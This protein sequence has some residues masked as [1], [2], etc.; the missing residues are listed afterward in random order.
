MK[1]IF[2]CMHFI[3]CFLL[4]SVAHSS[5]NQ[6]L[7]AIGVPV[8]T[9]TNLRDQPKLMPL[10]EWYKLC[11]NSLLDDIVA[12]IGVNRYATPCSGSK[13]KL[14][15]KV[16]RKMKEYQAFIDN[17]RTFQG[18]FQQEVAKYGIYISIDKWSR[19][20]DGIQQDLLL[21]QQYRQGQL[22]RSDVKN[23]W[24]KIRDAGVDFQDNT[25]VYQ[26]LLGDEFK[27][28]GWAEDGYGHTALFCIG[29]LNDQQQSVNIS[30]VHVAQSQGIA[31]KVYWTLNSSEPEENMA[32]IIDE[33]L[34]SI[35]TDD[36]NELRRAF[37][38]GQLIK[39]TV[40]ARSNR[41]RDLCSSVSTP[42]LDLQN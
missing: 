42:S 6:E 29:R 8:P 33:W 13:E 7:P 5:Q 39:Q 31:N 36:D 17:V 4:I 20:N 34:K 18:D 9:I 16:H 23:R 25:K 38:K 1:R 3:M 30:K 22:K 37:I 24:R 12:V 10:R 15:E 2:L 11:H 32:R 35:G 40:Q 21:R 19:G 14:F 28:V 41:I 26:M 27:S